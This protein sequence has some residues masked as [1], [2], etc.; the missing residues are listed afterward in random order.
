MWG[1]IQQFLFGVHKKERKEVVIEDNN[2]S[3]KIPRFG[4][5]GFSQVNG[6][7]CGLFMAIH[8]KEFV[9]SVLRGGEEYLAM[10]TKI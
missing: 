2:Q 1:I 6:H 8:A 5:S 4:L 9:L 7:D 10:S 3:F